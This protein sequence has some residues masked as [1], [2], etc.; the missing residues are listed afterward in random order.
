MINSIK[1]AIAILLVSTQ[2]YSATVYEKKIPIYTPN[3]IEGKIIF[4]DKPDSLWV[5]VFDFDM[6]KSIVEGKRTISEERK[7]NDKNAIKIRVF[8]VDYNPREEI[9]Y[10]KKSYKVIEKKLEGKKILFDCPED[11]VLDSKSELFCFIKIGDIDLTSELIKNGISKFVVPEKIIHNDKFDF[12]EY[13]NKYK[14]DEATAKKDRVGVWL[15]A[16]GL[17]S[18]KKS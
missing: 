14:L 1:Y 13:F 4:I 17:F 18:R 2:A 3:W 11:Y 8:G 6:Y 7:R 5:H 12:S 16:L 15:P 9:P 10:F